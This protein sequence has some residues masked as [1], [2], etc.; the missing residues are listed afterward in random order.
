MGDFIAKI[1]K[2]GYKRNSLAISTNFGRWDKKVGEI[3][4]YGKDPGDKHQKLG[5]EAIFGEILVQKTHFFENFPPFGRFLAIWV[6][7]EN[8]LQKTSRKVNI[9]V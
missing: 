6:I 7:A 4:R 3:W 9:A 8:R 5:D 1:A 2:I